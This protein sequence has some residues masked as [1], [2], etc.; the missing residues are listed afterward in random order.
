MFVAL[1]C[2]AV[3][4]TQTSRT[5]V[6]SRS[7]TFVDYCSLK[8][9]SV[10]I[11]YDCNYNL[12]CERTKPQV[13]CNYFLHHFRRISF[14]AHEFIIGIIVFSQQVLQINNICCTMRE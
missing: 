14:F 3:E 1:R 10:I 13:K 11:D 6:L 5:L 8:F 12:P 9:E 2:R 7:S 4:L